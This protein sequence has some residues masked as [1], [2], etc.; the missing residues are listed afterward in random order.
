MSLVLDSV[1]I[2][3]LSLFPGQPAQATLKAA[4]PAAPATAPKP[5]DAQ[6]APAAAAPRPA[7]AKEAPAAAAPRPEAAKPEAAKAEPARAP[8]APEVKDLVDRMQAFYE[9]TGD[10]T[11]SFKQEYTYK[12]FKRTQTSSGKVT[13]KKPALMRWEYEKPAPKTFVLTGE[14]VYVYDPEAR[15]L[16]KASIG[17]NQLS[18]SVTFLWGRGKL[19]DEFAI[20][21]VAC[22]KCQGTLLELTPYKPDPRFR[23]ARFEVDPK[24]AQVLRS[25]VIDPDGSENAITFAELKTN[26]GI[27]QDFFKLTPPEGTQ[28]VDLSKQK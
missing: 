6:G 7:D 24:T 18:V 10:F 22:D 28:I 8:M 25:I 14:K 16:T 27:T 20:T 12:A 5:P 3:L 17:S 4:A 19:A 21:R 2:A 26:Q 11:S 1:V 9:K 23:K 15:T 13:F